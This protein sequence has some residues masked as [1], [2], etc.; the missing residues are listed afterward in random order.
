[1]CAERTY[2]S[3]ATALPENDYFA[4]ESHPLFASEDVREVRRVISDLTAN[5]H[6]ILLEGTTRELRGEVHGLLLGRLSLAS[7]RYSRPLVVNSRATGRRVLVVFPRAPMQVTSGGQSWFSDRPFVM[8]TEHGTRLLPQV[9]YGALVVAVDAETLQTA[10]ES[11]TGRRFTGPL[12]LAADDRPMLLAAP[13]LVLA[14][15][16]EACR[17]IELQEASVPTALLENHLLSALAVGVTPFLEAALG[18]SSTPGG[19]YLEVA[20]E[21][22]E[23]N[24]NGDLSVSRVA[25]VCGI[26]ERQLHAAFR[27]RL[28]ISPAQYVRERRLQAAHRLLSDPEFAANGSVRAAA[29]QVGVVHFGR[30]ARHFAERY[31]ETPS[32]TLARAKERHLMLTARLTDDR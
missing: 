20:R 1:M 18:P 29:T 8:G 17:S 4:L 31:D 10:V 9:G 25:R 26:S 22:V 28:S 5:K 13:D 7:I 30:F 2:S 32:Q 16:R 14:A 15:Y 21:Y 23:K 19:S 12:R 6:R 3:P 24:L 27:D 11:A